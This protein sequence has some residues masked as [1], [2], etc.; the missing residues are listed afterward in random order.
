MGK[1]IIIKESLPES[2]TAMLETFVVK[3]YPH[4]LGGEKPV[5]IMKLDLDI[6]EFESIASKIFHHLAEPLYYAHFLFG[7][8]MYVIFQ[9]ALLSI[10][11]GDMG[12]VNI[13]KQVGQLKGIDLSL[14][15]FDEMFK[16]DHPNG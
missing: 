2:I 7:K 15:K 6:S 14:M 9:N 3:I 10:D 12:Q 16:E 11:E 5:T 8:R 4:L 13:C 1:G